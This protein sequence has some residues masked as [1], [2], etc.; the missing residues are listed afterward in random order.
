MVYNINWSANQTLGLFFKEVGQT[1]SYWELALFFE[2]MLIIIIGAGMNK[3]TTGYSNVMTWLQLSSFATTFTAV[4]LML[5]GFINVLTVILCIA[6]TIIIFIIT[7]LGDKLL[8]S[9]TGV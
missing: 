1:G 4:L 9:P 3:K 2:F 5:G 8:G 6:V 7:E